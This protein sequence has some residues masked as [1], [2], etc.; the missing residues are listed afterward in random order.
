LAITK[1]LYMKD[2]GRGNPGKHLKQSIDYITVPEKCGNGRWVSAVNCQPGYAYEQMI[3]TK[4]LFHKT[5]KRQGY[6]IIISFE[7][8][9]V[10]PNQAFKI[11]GEFVEE[12]L[13]SKGYEAVYAIHDNTAHV[14][15]HIVFNSVNYLTGKKYR[16]EKGDWAK[17]IQ[18]VTNRLCEKY[19][20]ATITIEDDAALEHDTYTEW[21]DRKDGRFVWSDM[22][23]RDLD[24]CIIQAGD[25]DEF[26]KLL[27]DKGYEIKHNKYLAVRPPGMGRFR[28]CR[29][30]GADYTE[31]RIRERIRSEDMDYYRNHHNE[32]KII[33]VTVPYHIRR[34]KL[35]G[36][37]RK[38]FARLYRVGKLKQRPYSQAWKYREEI[39]KMHRLHEEYMFLSDYEVHDYEDL[40]RVKSEIGQRKKEVEKE[41][42]KMYK[43]RTLFRELWSRAERIQTLSFA[44]RAYMEGDKFFEE[45]HKEYEKLM[46]E[47]KAEGYSLEELEAIRESY[48][49]QFGELKCEYSSLGRS[50]RIAERLM[51]DRNDEGRT[52][53]QREEP[54]KKQSV[55]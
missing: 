15:G 38:Y 12:Y 1:I 49:E 3:K 31:E 10:T 30:F 7:E 55:R 29:F 37:Q 43:K 28:R 33:K 5:D 20:L 25:F 21:R 39:R 41:R 50:Y 4:E 24:A 19:G 23:K 16:Y 18:P 8:G 17:Y 54:V 9:E 48:R 14:H 36:I 35:T 27:S 46:G 2:C 53:L 34:A 47:I 44:E 26:L 11:V 51:N 42:R 40:M 45:E 22:I 52:I 32:A 6:H 13:G